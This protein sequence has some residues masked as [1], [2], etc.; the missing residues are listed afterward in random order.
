MSSP[1]DNVSF[2]QALADLEKIVCELEDGQTG[3]EDALKR[4]EQ[5]VGL[6]RRCHQQLRG[7]EQRLM[8]LTGRDEAGNA[9]TRPFEHSASIE[10][11]TRD[12]K[13]PRGGC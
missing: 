11:V 13:A 3:L 7:A 8:E 9:V 4:Y 5:G 1:K 2:E 12:G 6:L 10:A